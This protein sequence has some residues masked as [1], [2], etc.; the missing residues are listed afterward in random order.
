MKLID[1][2]KLIELLKVLT[3]DT[4]PY[5][6]IERPGVDWWERLNSKFWAFLHVLHWVEKSD[7]WELD[8]ASEPIKGESIYTAPLDAEDEAIKE[9]MEATK[10]WAESPE[11]KAELEE[12]KN[13]G[14]EDKNDA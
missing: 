6:G 9:A 11:G 7:Y 13:L 4:N 12:F 8:P 10:R 2:D 3:Y 1:R 14:R 5:G